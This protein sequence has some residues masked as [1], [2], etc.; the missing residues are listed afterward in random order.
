MKKKFLA[1]VICL[2]LL[3]PSMILPTSA[4]SAQQHWSGRNGSGVIIT[5][6]DS[7]IIVESELLT[8]D[9]NEF[10]S[11]YYHDLESFLAYDSRVTAEYTFYNPSDMTITATL[12]FPFGSMPDYAYSYEDVELQKYDVKINGQV[13]ES[14]LRHTLSFSGKD[15]D[16]ER[17]LPLLSD[18][19]LTYGIY[20]PD[21][22][23]TI[24]KFSIDGVSEENMRA[25]YF[26]FDIDP[27]D[28]D[29]KYYLPSM[30]GYQIQKDGDERLV[31]WYR[32]NESFALYV[33]GEP[34]SEMP[35]WRL[36]QNGAAEDGE[37]ISGNI[38]LIA[39]ES[40]TFEDLAMTGYDEE[41]DVSRVDWYNAV[42][43]DFATS[44]KSE[45][46]ASPYGYKSGYRGDLLRW[47]QYEITIAPGERLVN[48]V[49]APIYPDINMLYV[50]TVY[51]YTYLLSPASTW[52]EFGRLDIVINT[53]H[54]MTDCSIDGFEKTENGYKA[55]L[56]G[57]PRDE[58][59]KYIDL[60][61]TLS[62]DENPI[63]ESQ[64]P[65]GIMR[66]IVYFIAF[67][68]PLL[69]LI[70]LGVAVI[71]IIIIKKKR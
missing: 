53:P 7:P 69:L 15:F 64:T 51:D 38:S 59:G 31:G 60:D 68:W 25:V 62:T 6:G 9:I 21:A 1:I 55:T 49:S 61:F 8:F 10:P 47:Y 45:R 20:T 43:T 26:A 50:P 12:V 42:V 40:M 36:Y 28:T 16:L 37:E 11:N 46:I 67:Y 71:V 23:V 41:G 18:E 5:D 22:V 52:S 3:L 70:L 39:T 14:D 44:D 4:N 24:Y 34:L 57:L 66:N 27:A 30:A 58:E 19:Y 17:D 65:S 48:S 13:I 35:E 32:N 56:N 63:R 29:R 54:Y 33:I 2:L